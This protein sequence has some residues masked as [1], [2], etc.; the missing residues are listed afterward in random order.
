MAIDPSSAQ[1]ASVTCHV[2]ELDVGRIPPAP[3]GRFDA[4]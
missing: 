2:D 1:L 4:P 3:A